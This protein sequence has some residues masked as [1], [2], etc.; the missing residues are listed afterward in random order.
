[1]A[2]FDVTVVFGVEA[3]SEQHARNI[4]NQHLRESSPGGFA[5]LITDVYEI[6]EEE[7]DNG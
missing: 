5:S 4:I 3:D 6:D 2:G 1:M 7:Q